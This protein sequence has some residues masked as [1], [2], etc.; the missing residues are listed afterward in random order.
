[1]KKVVLILVAIL[2]IGLTTSCSKDKPEPVKPY[3]PVFDLK[4]KDNHT[5]FEKETARN[6]AVLWQFTY[7]EVKNP[8]GKVMKLQGIVRN[9]NSNGKSINILE[10]TV[11]KQPVYVYYQLIVNFE[12]KNEIVAKKFRDVMGGMDTKLAMWTAVKNVL[13]PN[14]NADRDLK[15]LNPIVAEM[16]INKAKQIMKN[17][18]N[19]GLITIINYTKDPIK[20]IK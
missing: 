2:F 20:S 9:E 14:F 1:M 18:F 11:G 4:V 7:K 16:V 13:N 19:A 17:E 15:Y 6:L 5:D 8:Q 12:A 10:N 3:Q